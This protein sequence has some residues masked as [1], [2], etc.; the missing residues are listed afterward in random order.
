M[1]GRKATQ[2]DYIDMLASKAVAF[3]GKP[4]TESL[5]IGTVTA[6][7][8]PA[9]ECKEDESGNL[10]QPLSFT[11]NGQPISRQDLYKLAADNEAAK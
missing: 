3:R 5:R 6:I 4:R 7:C 9:S 10:I 2:R 8:G 11:L 1:T